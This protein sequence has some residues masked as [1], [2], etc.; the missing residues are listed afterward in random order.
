V[1]IEAWNRFWYR[2]EP[3]YDPMGLIRM[4]AV[5]FYARFHF[6]RDFHSLRNALD[7]PA[8][9]IPT[10]LG[11]RLVPLPYPLPADSLDTL[12]AV[13]LTACGLAFIGFLTRPALFVLATGAL[14]LASGHAALSLFNHEEVLTLSYLWILAVYPSGRSFSVDAMIH[15]WRSGRREGRNFGTVFSLRRHN[16]WGYRLALA[17]LCLI[18]V[19]AGVSKLRYSDFEWLNGET[20]AFYLS[21]D[22]REQVYL[23]ARWE[24]GTDEDW[25]SPVTL[26]DHSYGF[27]ARPAVRPFAEIPILMSFLSIATIA[28]ELS[29]PL[30]L[31]PPVI[32]A[33]FLGTAFSMHTAIGYAM[34]LGFPAYRL[35]ILLLVDWPALID[36]GRAYAAHRRRR[37]E[38]R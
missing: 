38:P 25:K 15:W 27:G 34:Y 8:E 7:L 3:S 13:M 1:I 30:L 33:L 32:A 9:L 10:N 5:F 4:A 11:L 12:Q 36:K 24:E 31:D 14:Y 37:A 20:L 29:A 17:T 21:R 16:A 22:S 18:Y 2:D 26:V 23:G 35:F 19:T 28:L 6:S